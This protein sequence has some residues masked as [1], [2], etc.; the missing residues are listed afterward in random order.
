MVAISFSLIVSTSMSA[1]VYGIYIHQKTFIWSHNACNISI[2][3]E[4]QKIEGRICIAQ[5]IWYN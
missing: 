5:I 3:L 1:I 2:I 4:V